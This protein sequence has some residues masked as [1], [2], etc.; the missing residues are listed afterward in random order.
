MRVR[1]KVTLL[2]LHRGQLHCQEAVMG[3]H[4]VIAMMM[5]KMRIRNPLTPKWGKL[6]MKRLKTQ[7]TPG[8][9]S[10]TSLRSPGE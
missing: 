4:R 8:R 2:P 5:R 7:T 10:S 3:T 6:G 9:R 1:K